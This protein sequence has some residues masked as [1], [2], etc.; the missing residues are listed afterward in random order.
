MRFQ[1][2]VLYLRVWAFDLS[3][4][5]S[6]AF[7]VLLRTTFDAFSWHCH[8]VNSIA[9]IVDLLICD[10]PGKLYDFSGDFFRSFSVVFRFSLKRK[11]SLTIFSFNVRDC[12][13]TNSRYPIHDYELAVVL[14]WTRYGTLPESVRGNPRLEKRS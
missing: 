1:K 11:R 13:V 3:L 10:I 2:F 7:W 6:V 12:L 4:S 8:L 14:V 5:I 9:V